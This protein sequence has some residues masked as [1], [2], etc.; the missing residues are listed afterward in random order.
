MP[1]PPSL[2]SKY[3]SISS[4]KRWAC[5]TCQFR[6]DDRNKLLEHLAEHKIK[7]QKD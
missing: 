1:K 5:E 2:T 6:S 4:S 7:K 3:F